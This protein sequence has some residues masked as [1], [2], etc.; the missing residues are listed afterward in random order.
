[1]EAKISQPEYIIGLLEIE[2]GVGEEGRERL[3]GFD[4]CMLYAYVEYHTEPH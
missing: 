1:V 2:K 4:K 3:I